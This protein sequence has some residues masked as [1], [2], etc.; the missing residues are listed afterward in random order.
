MN[1][2]DRTFWIYA[3]I[4]IFF[5]IIGVLSMSTVKWWPIIIVLWLSSM[6]CFCLST[7]RGYY[8]YFGT[9]NVCCQP[10]DRNG[11]MM[12]LLINGLFLTM[13]IISTSWI[14]EVGNNTIWTRLSGILALLGGVFLLHLS[15]SF[16][17][18]AMLYIGFWLVL[19]SYTLV[20]W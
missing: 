10:R 6:M 3:S 7:Y 1:E 11:W 2:V 4:S 18:Y 8:R 13:L 19:L 5:G 17:F 20:G 15:G 16:D 14:Y 12:W 9:P